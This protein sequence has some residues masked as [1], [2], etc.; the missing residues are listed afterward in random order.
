MTRL[1][2]LGAELQAVV[3][4]MEYT[5]GVVTQP[6]LE[7]SIKRSGSAAWRI[8]NAAAV[9]GFRVAHTSAQGSFFF[10]FYL[11]VVTLPSATRVIGGARITGSLK[12]SIRLTS[13]GALQLYNSEDSAQ[14]GSD[15]SA[16]STATWYRVELNYDSTTLASTSCEARLYA[17]SDESSLLWNPSGTIDLAA[18]PTA[19]GCYTDVADANLDYIVDDLAINDTTTSFENTW[20]GEGEVICLRPNGAGDNTAWTRGGTDTGANW[21]QVNEAPPDSAQYVESNTSGQIDDYEM[22]ATPAALESTDTINVV[23]VGVFAAVSDATGA[24]PDIVLRIKSASGGTVEES[25]SLDLNS[26]TYN[27][28][29]PL[30]TGSDNCYKLTLYDLPGASTSAWTKSTLDTMQA[31]IRE[32]VTDT[33]FARIAALWVMVDHKPGAA[34]SAAG[35]LI[36]GRLVKHG[37]LQGRL[38]RP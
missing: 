5:A 15:S 4:L 26:V 10:R 20:C 17:A 33:H 16:I 37:I 24:D 8:V 18:T 25:A 27:G 29:A 28:P 32:A 3:S 34:A 35:P 22:E 19:F 14:V 30:P 1:T 13:A 11:Y 2:S 12:I 7:T 23:H 9:E 36:G 31:G 21:S 38:V 6:G